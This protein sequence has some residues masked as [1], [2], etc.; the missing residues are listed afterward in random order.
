MIQQYISIRQGGGSVALAIS[1]TTPSV[2]DVITLTATA[3]GFT[4]T[5]YTFTIDYGNNFALIVTQASNTYNWT[6]PTPIGTYSVFVLATDGTS[7]VYQSEAITIQSTYLLD[8]Y[9]TDDITDFATFRLNGLFNTRLMEVRRTVGATTTAVEIGL[10]GD[11]VTLNSPVLDVTVGSSTAATLGEFVAAT[12]YANPDG[13]TTNQSAF[14]VRTYR[15]LN[16]ALGGVQTTAVNQ[17][18]L[19]NAGVLDVQNG[20]ACLVFLGNQWLDFGQINVG[21][22]PADYSLL[23]VGRI[24]GGSTSMALCGSLASSGASASA[25]GGVFN[26]NTAPNAMETTYGVTG[27]G[28]YSG[29]TAP[30]INNAQQLFEHYQTSGV[31][32]LDMH[33]DG[34]PALALLDLFNTTNLNSGT[35]FKFSIGRWGEFNGFYLSGSAQ[36]VVVYNQNQTANRIGMKG[37]INTTLGTSW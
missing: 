30:L 29:R 16:G 17:P 27:G 12:G 19:V 15:Q 7:N 35:E 18:R 4:P 31:N 9:P 14:V 36:M 13:I 3:T 24:V 34:S 22:K 33:I 10:D 1:N 21:L 32:R 28:F 26:R 2:A 37:L 11:Y 23:T 6:V 8:V 20:V 5:S 25:Y